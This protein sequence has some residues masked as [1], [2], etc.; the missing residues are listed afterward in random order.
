M[1]CRGIA[2]HVGCRGLAEGS[3]GAVEGSVFKTV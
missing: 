1:W 3:R 2:V